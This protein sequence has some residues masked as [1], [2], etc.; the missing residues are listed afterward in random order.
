MAR[1]ISTTVLV[2][3][4]IAV[5]LTVV[6][7]PSKGPRPPAPTPSREPDLAQLGS[8]TE[9]HP[10]TRP[11]RTQPPR[12]RP[13]TRPARDWHRPRTSERREDRHRMVRRQIAEPLDGRSPVR[14]PRALAAMRHV[15]RHEFVRPG[16][17][18]S[19][20]VD[21][22]LPIGFGQTISQPYIVAMMTEAL[23]LKSGE[24][25]LE[26]GTGSGYQAAVLS[27]LT[28]HV[29]TIEIIEP[30]AEQAA[31]RYQKLGYKT[32]DA[33]QGDGYFGWPEHAPFD[34]II[35]TCAAGHVPPPLFKQLADGGRMVVPLGQ[36]GL[37]QQL[38]VITKDPKTGRP[39]YKTLCG[40]RFVPMTGR[41]QQ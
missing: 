2:L 19:A 23:Q 30:L 5:F 11:V 12:T 32:I 36:P 14:D 39:R 27:E 8:A 33:K 6:L 13:A 22:P 9:P 4:G 3:I 35:V 1:H 15:P 40:V 10:T 34:A 21:H 29:F 18:R 25:V 24:K 38:K 28:P 41:I 31:A 37:Y 7:W 17:A 26:I 20:Y 16:D